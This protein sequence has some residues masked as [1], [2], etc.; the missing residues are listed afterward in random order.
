MGARRILIVDD[1]RPTRKG[2]HALLAFLPGMEWAGEAENGQEALDQVAIIHPDVVVMDVRMPTMDGIEATQ[3]IKDRNPEIKVI[4]LS[5]YPQYQEEALAA[6]AD[7]FLIK[8]GP[9]E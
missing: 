6:G 7:L 5:L 2:L 9:P 1:Q 3:A 8:G 4:V